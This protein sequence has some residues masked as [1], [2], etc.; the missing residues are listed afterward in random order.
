MLLQALVAA[1]HVLPCAPVRAALGWLNANTA[2]IDAGLREQ[3]PRV[4][5]ACQATGA[6]S[7]CEV[8]Y[9]SAIEAAAQFE[10]AG[11]AADAVL[12]RL[13]LHEHPVNRRTAAGEARP[14]SDEEIREYVMATWRTLHDA[15]HADGRLLRLL[16]IL[17]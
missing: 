10:H 6:A 11:A 1:R 4:P 17:S 8:V 13:R 7:Y 15:Q 16:G 3:L 12:M 5:L 9:A 14:A 2:L